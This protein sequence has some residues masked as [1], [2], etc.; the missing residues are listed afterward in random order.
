MSGQRSGV[1][2]GTNFLEFVPPGWK[3]EEDISEMKSG[4]R[5]VKIDIAFN[6]ANFLQNYV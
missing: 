4:D 6:P 2:S 3:D 5:I 1:P